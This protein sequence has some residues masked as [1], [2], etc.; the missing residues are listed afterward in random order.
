MSLNRASHL[1]GAVAAMAALCGAPARAD[2]TP[3]PLPDAAYTASTSLFSFADPDFSAISSLTNGP[4]TITPDSPLV[5]LTVPTTWSSWGSPPNT[6][7]S[8]PRVLWTDGLTSLT[9][10][11]SEPLGIFGFEAQPNTST[12]S[13]IDVTFFAGITQVGQITLDVD[14]NG[15]AR[16][17]A[18][19]STVPFDSVVI[20]STD[21]F[22]IAQVRAASAL[23]P[24]PA[25][26]ANF[27]CAGLFGLAVR[28]CRR[29][30]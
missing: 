16:L 26:I 10:S 7:S 3:I 24:E 28:L 30:R 13:P 17:F 1:V 27:L 18:A 29:R 6:E 22:A 25:S 15:G 20:N 9:L 19:L 23:V 8:T 14:G 21:D 5:A 2:F 12:V 11:F 4:I